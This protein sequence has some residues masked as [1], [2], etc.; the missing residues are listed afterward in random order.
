MTDTG[1]VV[2][3]TSEYK[4][5]KEV[6]FRKFGIDLINNWVTIKY[7]RDNVKAAIIN[8]PANERIS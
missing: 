7:E 4:T 2:V 3:G 5:I 6:S 8:R 1:T